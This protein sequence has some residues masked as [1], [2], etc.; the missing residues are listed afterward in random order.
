MFVSLTRCLGNRYGPG[1]VP[2]V[3]RP[4]RTWGAQILTLQLNYVAGHTGP[5]LFLFER[6]YTTTPL[7]TRGFLL[8]CCRPAW[9]QP[10]SLAASTIF[11]LAPDHQLLFHDP[12][13]FDQLWMHEG[14]VAEE[15]RNFFFPFFLVPNP[16]PGPDG[17]RA[18]G[19][20]GRLRE[21]ISPLSLLNSDQL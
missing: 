17:P 19:W 16:R 15:K 13:L 7:T 18:S 2:R 10:I 4:Q 9:N 11:L 5:L 8:N 21:L 1:V 3:N 12:F 14:M 20:Y 6:T